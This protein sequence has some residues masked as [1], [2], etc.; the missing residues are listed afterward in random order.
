M[1]VFSLVIVLRSEKVNK[2]I[3]STL[4]AFHCLPREETS[5]YNASYTT[6][7]NFEVTF[8]RK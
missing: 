6:I 4:F 3:V 8:W 1:R 5:L 7:K 2:F